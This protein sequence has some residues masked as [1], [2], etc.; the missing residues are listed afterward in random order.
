MTLETRIGRRW[1]ADTLFQSGII[2]LAVVAAFALNDLHVTRVRAQRTDALV[3][4]IR[5]EIETNLAGQLK[6]VVYNTEV[7]EGI[8][9]LA[10]AGA[11]VVPGDIYPHGLLQ[12]PALT[13]AAWDASRY[14]AFDTV[15]VDVQLTVAA[16]YAEQRDYLQSTDI[17]L[18]TVYAQ[19]LQRGGAVMY[20][21]GVN[22]PL[23][24][25][26]MLGTYAE[27]ATRLTERYEAALSA[28]DD[29]AH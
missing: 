18:S 14:G 26:A 17:L 10:R 16:A 6:A 29:M 13:S 27:R 23:G 22:S 19:L 1:I 20:V 8:W 9:G 11:E 3:A 21:D 24:A 2:L 25:G 28:L 7:A 5:S 12:R 4:A 15:P